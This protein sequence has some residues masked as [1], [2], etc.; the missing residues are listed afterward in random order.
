MTG[1]ND[2]IWVLSKS[3]WDIMDK[4]IPGIYGDIKDSRE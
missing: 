1:N 4:E 3:Q 2:I